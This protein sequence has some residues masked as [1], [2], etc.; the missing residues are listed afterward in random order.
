MEKINRF[1]ATES[2]WDTEFSFPLVR[3]PLDLPGVCVMV[4][5]EHHFFQIRGNALLAYLRLMPNV[6]RPQQ[7]R[8]SSG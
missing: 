8:Q 3:R 6:S 7:G 1:A 2:S 5:V 4:K